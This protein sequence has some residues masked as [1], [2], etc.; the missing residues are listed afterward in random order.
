MTAILPFFEGRHGMAGPN[1]LS[2]RDISAAAKSSVEKVLA[3]HKVQ[4]PPGT[5]LGF[6]RPPWWWGGI[7]IRNP[8]LT[9]LEQAQSLA[10]EIHA[11]VAAA[12][13]SAK[14]AI[15]G[16]VIQGGQLTIGFVPPE[17]INLLE[18]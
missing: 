10:T 14:A 17:P 2:A 18:G 3:Q 12:A 9:T 11:G 7:I 5:P 16:C 6:V 4:F 15:P 8:G 13:P 1:S